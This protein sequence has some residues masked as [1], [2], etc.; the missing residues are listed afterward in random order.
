MI[1]DL[2]IIKKKYG[3]EMMHYCRDAFATILEEPG[4]LSDLLLTYFDPSK[5]LFSDLEQ[6][7][8]KTSFK[9]FIYRNLHHEERKIIAKSKTPQEILASVGYDLYECESEED[10]QSFKKY[11]APGERLCTFNGNRLKKCFVF[12]AVKKDVDNIKREDFK[13]P[14]R[15]DLYGTSVISLQFDRNKSHNLS[16]KNRYNH[17][18]EN[19]DATFSNN[20]DNIVEGLTD[21]F[22]AHYGLD[23]E[24][25]NILEIPH[26]KRDNH[27]K[28]YK[29]NYEINGISY[30]TNNTIIDNYKAIHYPKERYI[31]AD[32]YLIDRQEKT[33]KSYDNSDDAFTAMFENVSIQK[34]DYAIK[35]SI[36]IIQIVTNKGVVTIELNQGNRII[37]LTN[38]YIKKIDAYFLYYNKV[39]QKISLPQ[40]KTIGYCFLYKNQLLETINIPEVRIIDACFL[41]HNKNL[42]NLNIPK[43]KIIGN[44]FLNNNEILNNFTGYNLQRIGNDFLYNNLKIKELIIPHILEVGQDV[45][46]YNNSLQKLDIPYLQTMGPNFLKNNHVLNEVYINNEDIYQEF[47]SHH[48]ELASHSLSLRKIK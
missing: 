46:K 42:Q 29:C 34:I 14:E 17:T 47:L 10:I 12:F 11:Y 16:I 30:G 27:G 23:Q 7:N 43:V 48:P 40:C 32:Y 28:Y 35:N 9:D 36:K 39:L 1:D 20:L 22:A 37:S 33:V 31:L 2:K 26:Y 6:A 45:L 44:H 25:I 4:I 8:L 41:F 13:Y 18:V 21:S 38:P 3:E 19:P 15:Q 24:Y 5:E